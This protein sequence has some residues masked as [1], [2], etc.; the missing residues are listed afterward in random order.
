MSCKNL[1]KVSIITSVLNDAL[2]LK[3]AIKS[4]REQDYS[5]IEFLIIDGGSTDGT[6]EIIHE[7]SDILN[8][9][10]SESDTGI[11][12]AWN[13][14]I[15]QASGEYFCFLGADDEL[16]IGAISKMIDNCYS[17]SDFIDYISG[18]T[19]LFISGIFY[20]TTGEP[21][22]WNKFRKYLCT[23]HNAALHH[24][25]LYER[26]GMYNEN[27]RS[28]GDYEFLLR[29]GRSLKTCYVDFVTSRM[30]LGGVSNSS[31]KP[32]I[33]AHFA[34]KLNGV[35]SNFIEFIILVRGFSSYL[36]KKA[37]NVLFR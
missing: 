20:K 12:C 7:N 17:K 1:P 30:N 31:Y 28:A 19:D 3:K 11:Y 21:F 22:E 37:L 33:E 13:K 27:F 4:V 29:A 6:L 2:N 35:N 15:Q 24:K 32:L 8:Y 5:N 16:K 25:S 26:F 23:G 9:W 34:R 18:K 14:G 36:I 10:I